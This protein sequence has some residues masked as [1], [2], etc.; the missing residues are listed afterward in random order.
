MMDMRAVRLILA[1]ITVTATAHADTQAEQFAH[2]FSIKPTDVREIAGYRTP[3]GVPVTHILVGQ[4]ASGAVTVPGIVLMRCTEK[5]CRGAR[6]WLYGGKIELLGIGDLGTPGPLG[7]RTSLDRGLTGSW[8]DMTR[9]M[10]PPLPH[11][12]RPVLMVNVEQRTAMTTGSRFG[13][14]V[15]GEH[16]EAKLVLISLR[17]VDERSP[18]VFEQSL[19]DRYPT[20]AGTTTSYRVVPGDSLPLD[21]VATEQRHIENRSM[22]LN[23][24]PTEHRLTFTGNRYQRHEGGWPKSGCH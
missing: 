8:V 22:C 20:G 10:K 13:G 24:P 9:W 21:I 1:L 18:L 14:D 7:E 15:A 12:T 6:V 16:H 23:P 11:Y 5:E 2:F 3:P 4:F 17:A 19:I